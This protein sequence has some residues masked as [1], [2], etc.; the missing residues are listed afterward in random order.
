MIMN[1]RLLLGESKSLN[2][3][4]SMLCKLQTVMSHETTL[5][6][7]KVHMKKQNKKIETELKY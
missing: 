6:N 1:D 4:A 2:V 3:D 7:E 5:Q